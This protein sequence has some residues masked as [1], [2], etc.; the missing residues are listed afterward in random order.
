MNWPTLP[1]SE[2]GTWV[3]GGTPKKS[4]PDFWNGDIPWISA[5]SLK[6]FR[7]SDSEDRVTKAGAAEVS[8]VPTGSII[9]V[10]RG[11]SLAKEFRVGVTTRSV[12]FNQDLR[13]I[14]PNENVLPEYLARCLRG[15]QQQILSKVDNAAH[16]TKRLPSE[17]I[18]SFQ[19]PLPPLPEQR[20]IAAILDQADA[21]RRKRQK[22]IELTEKFLKSAFL[23]M[24]GDPVTN[25]NNYD[26]VKLIDLAESP[27][28]IKCGPFGTQLLKSEFQ[29]S[30]VPLWGIKQVNRH[31]KQKTHEFLTEAKARELEAYTILPGDIVM[32]RK[33]TIGNCS[34]YPSDFPPGIMHSDLLRIRLDQSRSRPLVTALQLAF[35]RHVTHQISMLSQ[36]A[37]M[38]GINV[39]KLKQI[40]VL[41]PPI[42]AQLAFERTVDQYE[43]TLARQRRLSSANEQ[44]FN[45][46]VQRAFRGEL[47]PVEVP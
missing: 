16:G 33:G 44:L 35:S 2:C 17:Q 22:A 13:A 34:V 37:I 47:S 26:R 27:E 41:S 36:G 28:S 29:K 8:T 5:K 40:E 24:F 32:T 6:T 15:F 7:L 12:A 11:M 45:S 20:R 38:A 14:I 42:D 21:I 19:I 18:Q 39:T 31:F 4:N 46:L 1:L 23:E 10:V 3:S 43:K 30:G 9:F 25:P